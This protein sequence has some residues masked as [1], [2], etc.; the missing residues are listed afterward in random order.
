MKR[1]IHTIAVVL[2]TLLAACATPQ[3]PAPEFLFHDDL[4]AAPSERMSSEQVFAV[5][6]AMKRFLGA[7]ITS[8]LRTRGVQTGLIEALHRKGQLRLEYDAST[9]RNAAEAFDARAGNCLSLVLMT[10]AFAKE[11][12]LHVRFQSAYL[13]EIWS[14][15]GDLLLRSGHVNVTLGPRIDDRTSSLAQSLTVDFLPANQLRGLRTREIS[16]QTVVAM[17]MNNRAVEALVRGGLDDSYAWAREAILQSPDFLAAQNTLGIVYSRHGNL[18]QAAA[19]FNH[20]LER[21]PVHTRAMSNLAEV[22]MRQGREAEANG[23][24]R[25]L[26]QIEPEPPFHYFNLGLAAM[27]RDDF[28]TARDLFAREVALAEYSAELHFHLGVANYR[29]G[30]VRQAT[31]H[32][33]IALENST[34]RGDRDVYSAKL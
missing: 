34:S 28:A 9:T 12:G 13:E 19:V 20:V 11:L 30:D 21:D 4:F 27:Q 10:A 5:S 24:Y 3:P 14:R 17:Y 26:A 23:L 18:P 15:S 31:K 22:Y 1:A 25:T 7:E 16:E 2:C 33:T 6:A 8:R 32:L 29:L